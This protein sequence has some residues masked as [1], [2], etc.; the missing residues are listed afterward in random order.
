MNDLLAPILIQMDDEVDAFWCFQ[1]LM[2]VL[3]TNFHKD[4]TGM[5]SQLTKLEKL[6]KVMDP[7]LHKA[8]VTADSNTMFFAYRWLLVLFKRELT[9]EHTCRL[10]EVL[11]SYHY[12]KEFHLFVAL[13]VL[14]KFRAELVVLERFDDVLK[15]VT[16]LEES[17]NIEELL[18][19]ATSLYL[20]FERTTDDE[21]KLSIFGE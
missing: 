1:G 4:Q 14:H 5:Q 13:A 7:T 20:N 3:Y 16:T 2:E 6:V 12:H 18:E 11:W 21:V 19:I 9:L 10:W 15:F 8:L 17:L